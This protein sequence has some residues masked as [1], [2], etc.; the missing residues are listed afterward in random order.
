MQNNAFRISGPDDCLSGATGGSLKG[1]PAYPSRNN[2]KALTRVPYPATSDA[3]ANGLLDLDKI[4]T[5]QTRNKQV[6]NGA[7]RTYRMRYI[8]TTSSFMVA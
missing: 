1:T 5:S 8:L 4:D 7:L 2:L 6:E 3:A